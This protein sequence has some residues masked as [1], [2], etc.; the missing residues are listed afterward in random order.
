M[1]PSAAYSTATTISPMTAAA[2]CPRKAKP[3]CN[4]PVTIS[5]HPN[6]T[7]TANP[8]SGGMAIASTPLTIIRTLSTIDHVVD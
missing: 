1:N 2:P 3:R 7:V 6:M 8:A 5:S 4:A